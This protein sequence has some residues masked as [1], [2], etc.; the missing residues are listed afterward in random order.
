MKA[1]TKSS[2][3]HASALF[4]LLLSS[5]CL[6]PA[7]EDE[8]VSRPSAR[9]TSGVSGRANANDDSRAADGVADARAAEQETPISTDRPGFLFAP[10]LVPPRRLQIEAG[11]TLTLVDSGDV[12]AWSL[13]VAVRYGLSEKLELRASLPTWTD[14]RDESGASV[15]HDH[16][17]GDIEMGA[18][19]ALAPL[20]GGPLALQGSVR[21][22]T[23]ADDF[24]TD[25]VGG[26]AFLLHGRDLGSGYWLQSMLGIS[27]VP[28]AGASDQT[29]GAI[30]ALVSHPLAERWSAYV[31]GT[32]LPG[33][34]HTPGQSYLGAG[35]T[36]TPLA[37]LQLD[38]SADF[39][40]DEDAADAIAAIGV[41]WFF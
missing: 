41:S 9:L 28:I 23:G 31:E 19:L 18:K 32:A 4:G 36:W 1:L 38:L 16:G 15:V 24:T 34:Q 37:R 27:Y 17:F 14:V 5:S 10:T 40:L 3:P 26:T 22:P 7:P 33:L 25:S 20:A 35:L 11:P 29:S 6:A 21:L 2:L 30:G 39:G 12:R 13:P 8:W